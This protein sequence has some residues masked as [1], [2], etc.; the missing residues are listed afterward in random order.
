MALGD[1]PDCI[2]PP[3]PPPSLNAFAPP[4]AYAAGHVCTIFESLATPI[5]HILLGSPG[6][7][8][9]PESLKRCEDSL[10]AIQAEGSLIGKN[11]PCIILSSVE[12]GETTG[13]NL[14]LLGTLGMTPYNE[15]PLLY[16][17]FVSA[18]SP[19]PFSG[20]PH[21]HIVPPW[22][23][24]HQWAIAFVFRSTRPL[25]GLWPRARSD[26]QLPNGEIVSTPSPY[27]V[28]TKPI[29]RASPATRPLILQKCRSNLETWS[30]RCI[31]DPTLVVQCEE[32]FRES[33]FQGN[34]CSASR[35]NS[36]DTCASVE[37][38]QTNHGRRWFSRCS[39][40]LGP[41]P[42][43]GNNVARA[44]EAGVSK[45]INTAPSTP[46]RSRRSSLKRQ[47]G[48]AY[49]PSP[50]KVQSKGS[51]DKYGVQLT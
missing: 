6:I 18:V 25:K 7:Q 44:S 46:S 17:L 13:V 34:D 16:R 20:S 42:E 36:V 11:R 31:A 8:D 2:N 9:N 22:T 47:G 39:T 27:C 30:E 35:R 19:N 14:I 26:L 37:S 12:G 43:E 1:C 3:Q 48:E 15:L 45:G 28:G 23:N 33:R 51:F 40:P 21:F 38:Y 32:G 4:P 49:S 24:P 50:R 10:A 5:E 29:Y 41:L